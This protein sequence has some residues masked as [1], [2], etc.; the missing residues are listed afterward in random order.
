MAVRTRKAAGLRRKYYDDLTVNAQVR[1]SLF[2]V[3]CRSVD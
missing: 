1:G 2:V 3:A